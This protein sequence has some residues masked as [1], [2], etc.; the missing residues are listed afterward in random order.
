MN[1][2]HQSYQARL[3]SVTLVALLALLAGLTP[4]HAIAQQAQSAQSA[5]QSSKAKIAA[6]SG[7]S[8]YLDILERYRRGEY[9]EAFFRNLDWDHVNRQLAQAEAAKRGA[10]ESATE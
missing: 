3:H 9:V 2:A 6:A 10:D 8:A 1:R 7:R 4:A 5:Q